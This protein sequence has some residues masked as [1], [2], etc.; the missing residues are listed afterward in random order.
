VSIIQST[1][2]A[3]GNTIS[4]VVNGTLGICTSNPDGSMQ[5]R[6]AKAKPSRASGAGAV[7]VGVGTQALGEGAQAYGPGAIARGA[8]S[9][10]LGNNA[11]ITPSTG[12]DGLVNGAI[13]IGSNARANADPG[14]A[15]GADSNAA[16]ANSVALGYAATANGN[17]SVA[18]GAGSVANRAN[19]VSVGSAQQQR[20]ITNVAPGT[21]GTD[22]VNVNQLNSAVGQLRSGIT[23]AYSGIAQVAALAQTPVFGASGNSL[24]AGVGT[25]AGQS[26]I[27]VQYSHLLRSGDRPAF[28]SFGVAASSGTESVLAHAGVS[29]GW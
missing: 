14:T 22:A 5:C 16:G 15:L 23:K 2:D 18:L 12:Q 10:A 7:A 4:Q 28:V 13:A 24:T 19:S 26:A 17:N 21:A 29:F 6:P 8:G 9:V 1:V 27:G 3:Q 11:V 20:Q 25:Y